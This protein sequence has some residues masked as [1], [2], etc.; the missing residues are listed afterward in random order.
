MPVAGSYVPSTGISSTSPTY[1]SQN[2]NFPKII[3]EPHSHRTDSFNRHH[4]TE[5]LKMAKWKHFYYWNPVDNKWRNHE[6]FKNFSSEEIEKQSAIREF[7]GTEKNHCEV[8]ILLIQCY[9][10]NL[11]E[12]KIFMNDGDVNLV[13]QITMNT[14]LDFHLNFLSSLKQRMEEN[15]C[16]KEISDIIL[17]RFSDQKDMFKVLVS[18][19]E[20]CSSLEEMKR[21]YDVTIKKNARFSAY[22]ARLNSDPHFKGRDYKSCLDLLAQRCTKYP[23][24]L[25][26]II[27]LE[28]NSK[29]LERASAS[30]VAMRKFTSTID[31]NL[32]KCE[33]N[34][35]WESIRQ[36]IDRND[37]GIFDGQPF[38]LQDL[39]YQDPNDPRKVNCITQAYF[40][41]RGS[42]NSIKLLVILFDDIIVLFVMKHNGMY[43]FNLDDHQAVYCIKKTSLRSIERRDAFALI[44]NCQ[45][46]MDMLTIEFDSKNNML[47]LE[48]VFSEARR[49]LEN[50]EKMDGGNRGILT[51]RRCSA[52]NKGTCYANFE[53]TFGLDAETFKRYNL[54]WSRMETLFDDKKADDLMMLKYIQDRT[55]WYKELKNHI[56]QMPFATNK[57]ISKKTIDAIIS[58][59]NDLNRIKIYDNADYLEC[60]KQLELEDCKLLFDSWNNI[61]SM[62]DDF[63]DSLKGKTVKRVSTYNGDENKPTTKEFLLNNRRHTIVFNALENDLIKV[64]PKC[65]FSSFAAIRGDVSRR[66]T[67]K[68]LSENASLRAEVIRLRSNMASLTTQIELMKE[69]KNFDIFL[70]S[71]KSED[72]CNK[73]IKGEKESINGEKF[74]IMGKCYC[75]KDEQLQ[76]KLEVREKELKKNHFIRIDNDLTN[77][78]GCIVSSGKELPDTPDSSDFYNLPGAGC[79]ATKI[80]QTVDSGKEENAIFQWPKPVNKEGSPKA[81]S[82]F[83]KSV[84]RSKSF[85]S[86]HN[87]NKPS[88]SLS[89]RSSFKSKENP[90]KVNGK[91]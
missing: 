84:S 61:F 88:I 2:P 48:K 76:K 27:K 7:I 30:A 63:S 6:I 64:E 20:L 87:D 41:P 75:D 13:T 21:L 26:R 72:A 34:R 53:D 44:Y 3:E 43:F 45:M 74:N 52:A 11:K 8:L 58:M 56:G 51:Y 12:Q 79:Y 17:E 19:T 4:N 55:V 69:C 5:L 15:I 59:F 81:D 23:L 40:K 71:E 14:L 49:K 47:T 18:Y 73:S 42:H 31:E 77:L 28:K 90:F 32:K 80:S 85:F 83:S 25:E 91:K 29:L 16:I 37:V 68:L 86:F 66:A 89:A 39:I 46:H 54:W 62:K 1:S 65:D 36:K 24:L 10:V 22:C 9:H 50:T 60:I 70:S 82:L 35:D 57:Q 33:L 78:S 38:T 67:E